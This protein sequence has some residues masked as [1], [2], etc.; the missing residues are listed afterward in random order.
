MVDQHNLQREQRRAEQ[1]LPLAAGQAQGIAAR[2]AEQIQPH[3]TDHH[4]APQLDA[5]AAAKKDTRDRHQHHIERRH[6]PGLGCAGG[7]NAHLLRRRRR[8]QRRTAENTALDQ[9]LFVL[10]EPRLGGGV[11]PAHLAQHSHQPQQERTGQP[12]AAR[13]KRVRPHVVA[14]DALRD[15]SCAPDKCAAHQQ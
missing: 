11:R 3:H 7:A 14:A 9:Y 1:Q 8:K 6:K 2:Q 5:G 10:P 4:A 12:A 13:Q 15:E